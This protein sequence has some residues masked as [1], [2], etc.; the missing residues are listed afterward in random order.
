[1]TWDIAASIN[2]VIK[3]PD[4]TITNVSPDAS[5]R[6]D[7]L[8]DG[9]GR[10]GR[11]T[12]RAK[13]AQHVIRSIVNR[14]NVNLLNRLRRNELEAIVR[15][16]LNDLVVAQRAFV[17]ENSPDILGWDV[18]KRDPRTGDFNRL[19]NVPIERYFEDTD[20]VPGRLEVYKTAQRTRRA[21]SQSALLERIEVTP[22]ISGGTFDTGHTSC[23]VLPTRTSVTFY[24]PANRTFSEGE[25]ISSIDSVNVREGDD[26]RQV[27]VSIRVTTAKGDPISLTL[28][29]P[30]RHGLAFI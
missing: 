15:S 16:S 1:M 20:V 29:V 25:I 14:R 21:P 4:G 8:T 5:F 30:I 28:P 10:A 13:L 12:S 24:F 22:P 2:T 26:P 3:T 9:L 19:N 27:V 23:T 7:I 6:F 18:F 17:I 11:V